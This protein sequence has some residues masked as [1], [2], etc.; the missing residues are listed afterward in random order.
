M[1]IS[2]PNCNKKFNIEAKLIPEKGRLL[3]CSNCNHKWHYTIPSNNDE[4]QKKVEFSK[5][6]EILKNKID[7]KQS[8]KSISEE[9]VIIMQKNKINKNSIDKSKNK[10]LQKNSKKKFVSNKNSI[11][12]F[13]KNIIVIIITFSAIIL[14]LDTFKS[15][16]SNYFPIL[17][18]MLDSFYQTIFDLNSFIKD[19]IS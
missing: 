9:T 1:I 7:K 17:I 6:S 3:Q 4:I 5:N 16:I 2:C 19:L 14:I 18:P 10:N 15:S 12:Y 11:E 13:L 8:V